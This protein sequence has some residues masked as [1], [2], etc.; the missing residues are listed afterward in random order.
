M[1]LFP[2]IQP[3]LAKQSAKLPL[4]REIAWDYKTNTPVWRGGSPL[5]V[6]GAEAV[7]SWTYRA[8]QTPRYR[9]A[10]YTWNYGNE[11]ESLIGT[12][13]SEELKQSEAARYVRECLLANLYISDV[14]GISVKFNDNMLHISCVLETVYGEVAVDV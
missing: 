7:L 13:F 12:A 2:I 3:E 6:T 4:C 11:C 9:Y 14:T 8:L 10:V 5:I 1:S